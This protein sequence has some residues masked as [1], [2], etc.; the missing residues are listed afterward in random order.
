MNPALFLE[1][2]GEIYNGN[3]AV[4]TANERS[5]LTY[6]GRLRGYRDVTEST[7]LDIGTSFAY[8]HNDAGPDS[9][10]RLFGFDA[11]FRYRPLR[12][13][14]LR[15]PPLPPRPQPPRRSRPPKGEPS[16]FTGIPRRAR[17]SSTPTWR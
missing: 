16:R 2:T 14:R 17:R 5:Q 6:V 10:T 15:L 12:R 13:P 7:N 9:I 4:F 8:G 11:T 1:A 3:N